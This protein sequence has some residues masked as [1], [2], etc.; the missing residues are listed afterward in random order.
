MRSTFYPC[1]TRAPPFLIRAL[2][3]AGEGKETDT[4]IVSIHLMNKLKPFVIHSTRKA[5]TRNSGSSLKSS[6]AIE[7]QVTSQEHA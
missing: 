1:A 2:G 7:R 3:T 5:F 6:L 4:E